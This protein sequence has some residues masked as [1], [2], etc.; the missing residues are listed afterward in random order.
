MDQRA[1]S[2]VPGTPVGGL[3]FPRAKPDPLT[4]YEPNRPRSPEDRTI[5]T[6]PLLQPLLYVLL[7]FLVTGFLFTPHS[8]S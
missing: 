1:S 5:L 4:G 8:S 2:L 7:G 6:E 3:I